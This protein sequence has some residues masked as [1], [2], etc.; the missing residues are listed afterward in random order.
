M[1]MLSVVPTEELLA[2][3]TSV[4]DRTE[5]RREVRSVL[6]GFKLRFGIRIVI[7]DG[8]AVQMLQKV[9]F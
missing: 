1:T 2:M 7:R 3:R 5:T 9:S 8:L 6:Q 4:F